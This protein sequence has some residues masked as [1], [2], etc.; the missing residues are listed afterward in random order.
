MIHAIISLGVADFLN[1]RATLFV[2][3]RPKVYTQKTR[4]ETV[5]CKMHKLKLLT[6]P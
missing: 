5:M 6:E 2:V 1:A 4:S 3:L